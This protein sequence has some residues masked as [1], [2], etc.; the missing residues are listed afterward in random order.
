MCF[1]LQALE[2]NRKLN[3]ST[4]VLMESVKQ[5]SEI[6]SHRDGLLY[7]VPISIKD[8]IGYKVQ[9]EEK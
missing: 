5:L 9:R 8:N 3:C 1:G 6:E 2:V 7:G 4:D